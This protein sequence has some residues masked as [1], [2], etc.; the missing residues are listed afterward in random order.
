MSGAAHPHLPARGMAS[1][2]SAA[3]VPARDR[4][5]RAGTQMELIIS[6]ILQTGVLL[7]AAVI[8]LGVLLWAVRGGSGYTPGHYPVRLEATLRDAWALRPL[9]VV[10]LGLGILVLTPVVRVAASALLFWRE[11]D[12]TYVAITAAVLAMLVASLALGAVGH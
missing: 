5:Q 2:S 11:R 8:G 1:A 10:Q 7:S 4:A 9:A 3:S 12:W 6:R